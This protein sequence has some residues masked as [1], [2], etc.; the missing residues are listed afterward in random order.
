MNKSDLLSFMTIVIGLS[1]YIATLRWMI[2]DKIKVV[3]AAG[4]TQ[5]EADL[6]SRSFWLSLIDVFLVMSAI[7]LVVNIFWFELWGVEPCQLI[8]KGAILAFIVAFALLIVQHA[9]AW[10]KSFFG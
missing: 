10:K 3:Q 6:R 4:E 5:K 2:I 7:L 9:L 1:A 8:Q